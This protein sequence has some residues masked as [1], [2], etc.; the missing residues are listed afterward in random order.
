[1]KNPFDMF[2]QMFGNASETSADEMLTDAN[3]AGQPVFLSE[4][5][6]HLAAL[7]CFLFA[8][9]WK[10]KGEYHHVRNH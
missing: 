4:E 1:M 8:D 10:G 6:C 3:S 2:K 7:L 5:C 9:S